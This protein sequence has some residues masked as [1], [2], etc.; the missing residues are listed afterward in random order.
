MR[1]IS[2]S[3]SYHHAPHGS[4]I[5]HVTV[6]SSKFSIILQSPHLCIHGPLT[7]PHLFPFSFKCLFHF[8]FGICDMWFCFLIYFTW[9][10]TSHNEYWGMRKWWPHHH[11]LFIVY[12]LAW[13]C[14]VPLHPCI[15]NNIPVE[16]NL[17]HS[18]NH[19]AMS[20]STCHMHGCPCPC[21]EA[22]MPNSWSA[23]RKIKMDFF[24]TNLYYFVLLPMPCCQ[25]FN[26]MPTTSHS[27]PPH[28]HLLPRGG[29]FVGEPNN[30]RGSLWIKP[31]VYEKFTAKINV[32]VLLD[33]CIY[34]KILHLMW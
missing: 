22:T 9:T 1:H 18:C 23:L 5:Q 13:T 17:I 7:F 2:P 6:T 19:M 27:F 3:M 31:L 11:T 20:M 29:L 4:L 28:A 24:K 26:S 15:W 8:F 14:V 12:G 32:Y 10:P 16:P 21:S 34:T 33:S 25:L 30:I